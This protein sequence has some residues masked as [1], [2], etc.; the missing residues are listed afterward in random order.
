V[1][2]GKTE[3]LQRFGDIPGG[4]PA[5]LKNRV[6]HAELRVGKSLLMMSD[7]PDDEP[8][9]Q[10]RHIISIALDFDDPA[11]L[12]RSFDALAVSGTVVEPIIDAP[13]GGLFG[14]VQDRFGIAWMVTT[15]PP[16]R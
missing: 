7:G 4:C 11:E 9:P 14:V 16:A 10:G 1:L 5:A 3:T 12:R 15:T 13:W 6:M 8:V 2:G